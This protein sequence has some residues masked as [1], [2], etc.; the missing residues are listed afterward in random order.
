MR[1]QN[2]KLRSQLAAPPPGLFTPEET[3]ALAQ[4]KE[5]A[6][7]IA[8]INN[9]KQLALASRIWA[10]DHGDVSPPDILTMSN[11][12]HTP[13]ILVCPGDHSR[14]PAKDWAAYTPAQC[15]YDYLAASAPDIEPQRVAF[16]CPVHGNVALCDGSVQGGVARDHP[17][18]LVQREG[19]L[20]FDS[21]PRQPR[22]APVPQPSTPPTGATDP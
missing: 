2:A 3:E 21:E 6:E 9:M 14:E 19:K 17:E 18:R 13:K 8:C 5:R 7:R 4:A 22:A 12:V 15:S 11:E 1:A 16:R 20:Y 10:V